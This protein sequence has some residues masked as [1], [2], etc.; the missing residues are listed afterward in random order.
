MG[1]VCF[2]DMTSPASVLWQAMGGKEQGAS[3]RGGGDV[4]QRSTGHKQKPEAKGSNKKS[5]TRT[6]MK[7]RVSQAGAERLKFQEG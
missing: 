4:A 3:D 2:P 1:S 6:R 5:D 7:D